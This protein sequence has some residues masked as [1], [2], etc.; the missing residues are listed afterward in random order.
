MADITLLDVLSVLGV[1]FYRQGRWKRKAV[2]KGS[3]NGGK[4]LLWEGIAL[5]SVSAF[6]KHAIPYNIHTQYM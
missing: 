5:V 3:K 6:K 4:L 2:N 1:L